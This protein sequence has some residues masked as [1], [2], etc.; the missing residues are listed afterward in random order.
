[1]GL[2]KISIKNFEMTVNPEVHQ[3]MKFERVCSRCLPDA[4]QKC[5]YAVHV[6]RALLS[7][8]TDLSHKYIFI[9]ENC[10]TDQFQR[11][12]GSAA[13]NFCIQTFNLRIHKYE[14]KTKC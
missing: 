8:P 14:R 6:N 7:A 4:C 5:R 13:H 12:L 2:I 1:M 11:A 10:T 9:D 3:M